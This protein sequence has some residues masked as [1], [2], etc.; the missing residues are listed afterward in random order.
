MRRAIK[1][2]VLVRSPD[3]FGADLWRPFRPVA[4]QLAERAVERARI[5]HAKAEPRPPLRLQLGK[6]LFD[7]VR[8]RLQALVIEALQLGFRWLRFARGG[9]WGG[10]RRL[11]LRRRRW[12]ILLCEGGKRQ[13]GSM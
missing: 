8:R 10:L 2:H 3:L 4:G 6:Q 5:S 11:S 9:V 7:V 13:E 1:L 12:R